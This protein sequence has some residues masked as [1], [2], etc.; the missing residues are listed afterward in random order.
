MKWNVKMLNR[1]LFYFGGQLLVAFG[2]AFAI[3]SSLGISPVSS[4]SFASWNV[5]QQHGI[6]DV[7]YGTCV[8]ISYFGYMVAQVLLLRREYNPINLLQIL[9][10]TLFG[11]FV[12]FTKGIVGPTFEMNYLGRL[13]FLGVAI[14]FIAIG[15]SFYLGGKIMPMPSEGLTMSV[16]KKLK[17]Y[18]FH[19]VKIGLDCLFVTIAII[20]GLVGTGKVVGVREG[21]VLT[22]LLVGPVMGFLAKW[23]NPFIQRFG[24]DKPEESAQKS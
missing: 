24:F 8:T 13:G 3:K 2:I 9:V 14:L 23:I 22:A 15:M 11:V 19:Q 21:T 16:A 12:D 10:S 4:P 7:T 6:L 20:I 5:L 17:K 18:P 1:L